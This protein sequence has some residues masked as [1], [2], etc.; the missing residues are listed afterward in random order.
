MKKLINRI[1]SLALAGAMALSLAACGNSSDSSAAKPT[2]APNVSATTAETEA[3]VP[4]NGS[5]KKESAYA[6]MMPGAIAK[7]SGV[8]SINMRM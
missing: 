4:E 7:I 1:L 6:W 2:E 3:A 5:S 8:A